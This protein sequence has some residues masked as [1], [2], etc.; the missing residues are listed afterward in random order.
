MQVLKSAFSVYESYKIK[1]I[2]KLDRKVGL[3]CQLEKGRKGKS[4]KVNLGSAF[5]FQLQNSVRSLDSF[6]NNECGVKNYDCND[7]KNNGFNKTQLNHLPYQFSTSES[8]SPRHLLR[9]I[10]ADGILAANI[11][12]AERA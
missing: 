10:I 6:E 7:Y 12:A 8:Q 3:F 1:F 5:L 2:S 4:V 9:P 11:I